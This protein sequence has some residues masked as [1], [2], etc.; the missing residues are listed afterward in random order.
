M[1][2]IIVYYKIYSK[3]NIQLLK[4][5]WFDLVSDGEHIDVFYI[6]INFNNS[7]NIGETRFQFPYQ[8]TL[9]LH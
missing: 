7:Q 5:I 4:I 3:F 6:G 2:K 8:N 1:K 9:D